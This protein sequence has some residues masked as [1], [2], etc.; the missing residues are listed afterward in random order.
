MVMFDGTVKVGAVRSTIL[1]KTGDSLQ[2]AMELI[3]F[4]GIISQGA[5][6]V[7]RVFILY[8][9]QLSAVGGMLGP[10]VVPSSKLYSMLK[11]AIAGG[12][13]TMIGPQPALTVGTGAAGKTTKL[14]LPLQAALLVVYV[15]VKHPGVV[16]VKT[17]PEVIVPPPVTVHVPPTGPSV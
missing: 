2:P 16:G 15:A 14:A 9:E 6:V 1:I 3:V 13:V 4:A 17:P 5:D 11:P 12:G 7:Y 8:P 10:H